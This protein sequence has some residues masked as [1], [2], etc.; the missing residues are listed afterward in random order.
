MCVHVYEWILETISYCVQ[1]MTVAECGEKM[2][3]VDGVDKHSTR[4]Y[5]GHKHLEISFTQTAMLMFFH[6]RHMYTHVLSL[7]VKCGQSDFPIYC[8]FLWKKG[9]LD[10]KNMFIPATHKIFLTPVFVVLNF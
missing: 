8:N 6:S 5:H 2:L 3:K 4:K 7:V 10:E 1:V 9:T